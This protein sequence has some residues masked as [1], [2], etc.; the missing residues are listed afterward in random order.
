MT[1]LRQPALRRTAFA[2]RDPFPWPIFA[3][4]ARD[5]EALGYSAVFL[6]EIAGR[7]ALVALGALAGETE[8]L[9]LGTGIVPMSSRTPMLTAM[10]A[11]AVQERSG[12]RLVLGSGTGPAGTGALGRLR[13]LV[14]TLRRLFAGDRVEIDGR[15]FALSLVPER[16]VPIWI[17]AL[18]PRAVRIGGEVAD[19]VLLN[20]CTP[21]RAAS[22]VAEI[23][24]SAE[25]AG[26][27][28]AAVTVG[29]YV[30]ASVGSSDDE[31][32]RA[33][34][35]AVGEYA[36]FPAYARQFELMGLGEHARIAAAAHEATQSDDVPEALVRAVCL[37]G[38]PGAARD[39]LR[40]FADAGVDL[41]VV[42]PVASGEDG[43]ASVAATLAA[44]APG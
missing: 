41:P 7:D 20:W 28:P 35:A 5:A 37:A 42:Y 39:R 16:P 29:V 30:R 23:R 14:V 27:D 33:L 31:A 9:L 10:A 44:L 38:E 32:L 1:D 24:K 8:R 3:G 36:S 34:R 2:L 40:A 21:E 18:G 11:A 43:P 4:L 22:A 12:G 15:S 25:G 17:S 19:G 26:R 13:E 6:P